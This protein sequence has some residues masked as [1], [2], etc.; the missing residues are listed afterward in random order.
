MTD[1][2]FNN[3]TLT[4][5]SIL[6]LLFPGSGHMYYKQVKK[7]YAFFLFVFM[8]YTTIFPDILMHSIDVSCS[9][10]LF[11]AYIL[12]CSY[13]AYDVYKIGSK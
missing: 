1:W 4:R 3:I 12:I 8:W 9:I 13:S 5:L 2:S 7:A 11:M 6:S 10:V